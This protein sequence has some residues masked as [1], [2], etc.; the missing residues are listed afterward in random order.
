MKPG[1]LGTDP[2][3]GFAAPADETAAKPRARRSKAPKAQAAGP[4][5]VVRPSPSPAPG[6]R[7]LPA[8]G[9]PTAASAPATT[10]TTLESHFEEVLHEVRAR[11]ESEAGLEAG[12]RRRLEEELR[13]FSARMGERIETLRSADERDREALA[14]AR[15]L[16]SADALARLAGR[17]LLRHRSLVVDAFGYDGVVAQRLEPVIGFLYEK[18]FRVEARGVEHVPPDGAAI[19]VANHSGVIPF[20]GLM[21]S[22]AVR[23]LHAKHRDVRWLVENEAHH[24]PFFGLAMSRLGAVRACPENA[25]LLLDRGAVVAVFPEGMQGLRKTISER[26][27]L[28]RFGRGGAIKLALRMGAPVI[29]VAVVGGEETYPVL[30]RME[31]FAEAIGVPFIPITP[32]FPVL[33]P[34]GLLPLPTRWRIQFGP[35]VPLGA[36]ASAADDAATVSRLN[37][38]VRGQVQG[39]LSDLLGRRRGIF[40]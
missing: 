21:I 31:M 39:M 14:S 37:E 5:A 17:G 6:S 7:R 3:E 32:T 40:R 8:R 24:F 16:L 19:L 34:L 1:R 28:Q 20:D 30:A 29:P 26:Y 13:L 12:S 10:L 11:L 25:T 33:G 36:S 27:R 22:A 35:P 2:L 18:W 4:D 15:S 23:R 38:R 9:S